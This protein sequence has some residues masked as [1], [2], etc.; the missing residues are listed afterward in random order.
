MTQWLGDSK[1]FGAVSQFLK[2]HGQTLVALAGFSFGIYRWW[3][4]REAMLH[5]RLEEY[6]RENDRRLADGQS[7]VL[8]ALQ[9]PGPGQ[10]FKLPL[11][12]SAELQSV[13]R[14][15]SWDRTAVAANIQSSAGWQLSRA[16]EGIERRIE[17]ADRT[18]GS[19]R[20]QLATAHILKGAIAA[21]G[22][23]KSPNGSNVDSNLDAL[24]SFRTALQIPG[25]EQN[26]VAK[27]LEAHQLRKLSEFEKARQAYSE[28]QRLAVTA[29]DYRSQR[30]AVAR[31][32]R[33]QAEVYQAQYSRL[34]ED[35]SREFNG[36]LLAHDL[37]RQNLPD[38]AIS[39]RRNFAPFRGWDLLEEGD[40]QY[41]AAFVAHNLRF[42]VI[43]EER[44]SE[45]RLAYKGVLASP[46][47]LWSRRAKRRL[48]K[49]AAEGLARVE[50][51][52]QE[53]PEFDWRWLCP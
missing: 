21:S 9:R 47:R 1:I 24:H 14:E 13:F 28:V 45:A 46:V 3:K 35:G 29:T 48:R 41:F 22:E 5:R 36:C 38:S 37:V 27:E 19:L 17:V 53:R 12:A 23:P 31:A 42:V 43:R 15:R 32:K 11:F 49:Q 4:Y 44:L 2:D 50:R 51:A 25:Q 18:V 6:L 20:S 10:R 40:L 8:S 33:H 34:L 16:I 7:Y 39:I 52:S 26:L 30:L